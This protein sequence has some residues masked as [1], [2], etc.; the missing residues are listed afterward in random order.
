MF[1]ELGLPFC[2][3]SLHGGWWVV[4][5]GVIASCGK[6]TGPRLSHN[7]KVYARNLPIGLGVARC[8][9]GGVA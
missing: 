3:A 1:V 6:E 9:W 2:E 8:G 7:R 4:R 5:A